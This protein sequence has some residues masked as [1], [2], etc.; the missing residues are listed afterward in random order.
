MPSKSLVASVVVGILLAFNIYQFAVLQTEN[1]QLRQMVYSLAAQTTST[2]AL[3]T[4][5]E[6]VTVETVVV[7][8]SSNYTAIYESVKDSV[9]LLRVFS[10]LGSAVG[11]GFVYDTAGHIVTNNHVVQ[12]ATL[13]RVVF[14]DGS[15][16]SGKIVGTDVDSDLAVVRIENPPPNLKPLKLGDSTK[17]KVGEEVVAI[18]NP[19]G[20][21][22]TLTVGVVSQKDRLLPTSRGYSIPG[23]IQTDAAINPGNS[24]GP[25]LNLNGEVVG[26]NTAIEPS[27]YGIGYAVPSAIVAR[28]VPALIEKGRYERSWLGISGTTL[29]PDIAAA[30]NAPVSKGVLIVDV[31]RG[32]PA[33]RAGLRGGTRQVVVNGVPVTVG[34]DIVTAINGTPITS[35]D[36]LILYLE[37]NTSPGQAINLNIIRGSEKIEVDVTLAA[38]P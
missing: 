18:G 38:R 2:P 20:L 17:L 16:Y 28:V 7:E 19:F 21:E 37:L 36:Q 5:Q 27:G 30:M 34:G 12:G 14:S 3:I 35:I 23:I 22:G 29:D 8:K 4:H 13:I 10:S 32:S 11:S 33:E 6:T 26:V 31:M 15:V 9:V 24:G 25:L 1:Q